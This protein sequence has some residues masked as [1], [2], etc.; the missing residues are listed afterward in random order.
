M[1]LREKFNFPSNYEDLSEMQ[2]AILKLSETLL[3]TLGISGL[4]LKQIANNLKVSP[5]LINHYYRNSEELIFDT[6]L[7]SYQKLVSK[8]YTKYESNTNSESVV[9]G[10]IQEMLDWEIELPGIGVLLEFPRQAI[11]SSGES[12]ETFERMLGAFQSEIGKIGAK[13]VTFMAS[14]V[15]A[16]Q[17][18]EKFSLLSTTKIVTLI[19]TE[20]KFAMYTSMLGFATIGGGLWIAG[21]KPASRKDSIWMKLGFDPKK[22]T[23]TTIDGFIQIIK[24]N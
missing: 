24:N 15:R 1:A 13:N 9:R 17:K 11:R 7:Y 8:I 18:N 3:G 23:T 12:V 21:R 4:E 20:K 22:Q 2:G 5:S 6:V 19:A 16:L 10:W 14:A